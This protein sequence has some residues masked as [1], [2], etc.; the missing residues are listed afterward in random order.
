M[1]FATIQNAIYNWFT[2]VTKVPAIWAEQEGG[3]PERP[4]ATLKLITGPVKINGRDDMVYVSEGKF[5]LKG[6]RR[7]TCSINVFG[8]NAHDILALARDSLDDP[9]VVDSLFAK[10][11]SI[12]DE[13]DPTDI[14]LKLETHWETRAQMDTVFGLASEYEVDIGIIEHV[15]IEGTV[16]D[17]ITDVV[18]DV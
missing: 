10:G 2:S 1:K 3:K 14:T 8:L 18:V 6:D 16:G 13:G 17:I 5:N 11:L 15:E 9:R 12:W 7:I 4:Y